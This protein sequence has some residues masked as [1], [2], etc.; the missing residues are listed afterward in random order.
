MLENSIMA[1]LT[2]RGV[3][4]KSLGMGYSMSDLFKIPSHKRPLRQVEDDVVIYKK[5][6][7][8]KSP[9]IYKI[10]DREYNS[11]IK[12]EDGLNIEYI[13]IYALFDFMK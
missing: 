7:S 12:K 6:I 5:E 4:H 1:E 2:K 13:P 11:F 3:L 8:S 9:S 10:K